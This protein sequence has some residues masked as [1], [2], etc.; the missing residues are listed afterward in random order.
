MNDKRIIKTGRLDFSVE[1]IVMLLWNGKWIII[2]VT[3]LFIGLGVV[4]FQATKKPQRYKYIMELALQYRLDKGGNQNSWVTCERIPWKVVKVDYSKA[5]SD[6]IFMKKLV[7]DASLENSN[8]PLPMIMVDSY[9]S[10]HVVLSVV[11][12]DESDSV[13]K[14]F[15]KINELFPRYI[16][17]LQK[18][19]LR[20]EKYLLDKR[21]EQIV[22]TLTDKGQRLQN[23]LNKKNTVIDRMEFLRLENEYQ[24]LYN[25]S[26]DLT[27]QISSLQ[28]FLE[29]K[30][31]LVL[32]SDNGI[33]KEQ[34]SGGLFSHLSMFTLLFAFLGFMIVVNFIILKAYLID[35]YK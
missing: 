13:S 7:A 24:I 31:L 17:D 1:S 29:D 2:I 27:T 26:L 16:S 11:A 34:V 18:D 35:K 33:R 6:S 23:L 20:L 21:K 22:S 3:L 14:L 25:L 19:K 12:I 30:D 5:L 15:L 32:R 8:T 4:L 9:D 10:L 28:V